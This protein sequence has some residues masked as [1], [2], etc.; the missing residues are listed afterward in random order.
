MDANPVK[1]YV[2]ESSIQVLWIM[3]TT[4]MEVYCA[5]VIALDKHSLKRT[6]SS[7]VYADSIHLDKPIQHTISEM[8][9]AGR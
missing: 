7:T 6:S 8:L 5:L 2:V 3:H 9:M 1:D 4:S